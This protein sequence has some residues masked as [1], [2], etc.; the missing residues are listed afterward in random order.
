M[1][2]VALIG[3]GSMGFVHYK[4][5]KTVKNAKVIA[6]ADIR[7]DMAKEKTA[8]D[9]V[10]IYSSIDE[11]LANEN[12]DMVDIC[13]PSYMHAEMAVKALKA[14]KHVLCEKPMSIKSIDTADMIE[15]AEKSGKLYMTAQ[16]V[17]F[18]SP[19]VYLKKIIDE[20]ELG[21]PVRIEMRRISHIPEKSWEHWMKDTS[22]SGGT[23]IDLT[24]HDIDFVQYA[25]GQPKDVSAVY[26]K[27]KNDDNDHI[28]SVLVYDG[29]TVTANAGWFKADI[30]FRAEYL[31]IFENGYVE[32]RDDKIVKNG[33][34]VDAQKGDVINDADFNATGS[35]GYAEEIAYFVDCIENNKK[36]TV[37]TPTS[38]QDSVKLMERILEKAIII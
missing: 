10:N 36:P 15:A 7:T 1:I 24:I 34:P 11:L 32:Y 4:A 2:K 33:E 21:A 22:K 26:Y 6:V 38:S 17:R 8:G 25:F 14:D 18:M 28:T 29:F 5:Y 35:D 13:T 16:V 20:G 23:P 30:P 31:A 3:I 12:P 27:I 37:V 19:Y 9:N